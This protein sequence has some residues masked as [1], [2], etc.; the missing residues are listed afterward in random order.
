MWFDNTSVTPFT[1]NFS[2]PLS[3]LDAA[4]IASACA[5]TL[6]A[7]KRLL[8]SFSR[9]EIASLL[10]V[11]RSALWMFYGAVAGL[12]GFGLWVIA[13]ECG[14]QAFSESKLLNNAVG[15]FIHSAYDDIFP[16]FPKLTLTD[17]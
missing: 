3:F 4:C 2:N 6:W 9:P 1:D 16:V 5:L 10:F 13:H 11:A 14:H 12:W 8:L 17:L 7:D 15:W